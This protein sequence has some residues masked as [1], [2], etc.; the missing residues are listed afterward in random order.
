MELFIFKK[1]IIEIFVE[2]E[3]NWALD[4]GDVKGFLSG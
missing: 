1:V 3:I 2:K 4:L